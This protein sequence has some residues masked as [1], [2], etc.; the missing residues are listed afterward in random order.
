MCKLLYVLTPTPQPSYILLSIVDI[1]IVQFQII[2]SL[3]KF[4]GV[5]R[6]LLNGLVGRAIWST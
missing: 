1:E 2:L 4:L 5:C 3:I 6:K